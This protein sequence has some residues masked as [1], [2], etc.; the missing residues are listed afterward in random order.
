MTA[1]PAP[2]PEGKC[3]HWL[4]H[5][6]WYC[7]ASET[8]FYLTGDRCPR[9]TP[10]ALAGRKEN[11]PDPAGSLTG[12]REAWER[13]YTARVEYAQRRAAGLKVF[14]RASGPGGRYTS[15]DVSY[16]AVHR[17]ERAVGDILER[18]R[19]AALAGVG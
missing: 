5:L 6:G 15:S 19:L 4:G 2:P 10:A 17:A 16:A 9:H 14:R 1:V 13:R 3:G 12:I 11:K 18:R 7:G 8:R